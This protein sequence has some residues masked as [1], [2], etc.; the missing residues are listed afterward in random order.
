MGN[1]FLDYFLEFFFSILGSFLVTFQDLLRRLCGSW[2][3]EANFG[4]FGLQEVKNWEF[5]PESKGIL[6]SGWG[7]QNF[8]IFK[9]F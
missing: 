1:F 4:N 3:S 9:I 6:T 8:G 7:L 5:W 2:I